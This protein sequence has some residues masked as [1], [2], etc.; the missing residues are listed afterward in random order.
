M[1]QRSKVGLSIISA[2]SEEGG[3]VH[4][5]EAVWTI[6][7]WPHSLPRGVAGRSGHQSELQ[8]KLASGLPFLK[9]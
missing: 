6:A 2:G 4:K 9:S 7:R 1:S 5:T 3:H 8:E